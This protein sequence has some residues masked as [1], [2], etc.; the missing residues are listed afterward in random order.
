M[1]KIEY[2]SYYKKIAM[3]LRNI[4][5]NY[6]FMQNYKIPDN[7]TGEIILDNILCT[8]C[9]VKKSKLSIPHD[10]KQLYCSD[11]IKCYKCEDL[12][13]KYNMLLSDGTFI[14]QNCYREKIG[15]MPFQYYN[16]NINST[17]DYDTRALSIINNDYIDF[18]CV[19]LWRNSK[20]EYYTCSINYLNDSYEFEIVVKNSRLRYRR[21]MSEIKRVYNTAK[22][23]YIK[24]IDIFNILCDKHMKIPDI[25]SIEHIC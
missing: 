9:T 24:C 5:A 13:D 25:S 8:K 23:K 20:T 18:F 14:C 6:L 1:A 19:F 12:S 17:D 7:S 3:Q 16:Y 11:C 2:I 10:A 15:G 21:N 22:D 4:V